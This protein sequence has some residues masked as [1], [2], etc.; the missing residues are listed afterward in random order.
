MKK[1]AHLITQSTQITG[2]FGYP[3]RH[4]LS[5]AMH[6]AAFAH[7][8]LPFVYL[9]FEVRPHDLKAATAAIRAL[10]LTGVNVTIPHKETIIPFLD[11][12]DAAAKKIGSVNTVVNI[13]G[14]LTGYNTDAPGFLMDIRQ[15]GC[16]PSNATALLVGSGGAA[17]AVA[18]GLIDAG[19][20]K[21]FITGNDV[22]QGTALCRRLPRT[23]FVALSAW[24][25]KIA[26][27]DILIN[28]TPIGMETTDAPLANAHELHNK[29]F[30][31]DLIYTHTT[32]L[33]QAARG[34]GAR[35]ADGSGMLLYQGALSFERWT[36]TKAP[37]AVMRGA[38]L[39]ALKKHSK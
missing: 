13:K 12:I 18:R 6:N 31:Y 2:L 14:K 21:L 34:A 28:A 35:Y 20:K 10:G 1:S 24:K 16:N 17:K 23:T 36:N 29:L 32:G 26:Q 39:T 7:T 25:E 9:P 3:V 4:T 33:L 8:G 37:V 38:L 15:C 11:R 30:V 5:P 19:A 22:R 27:A